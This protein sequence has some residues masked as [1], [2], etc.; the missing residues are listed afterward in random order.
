MYKI[1]P[2]LLTLSAA[3][4]VLSPTARAGWGDW[5][6]LVSDAKEQLG[7]AS[8]SLKDAADSLKSSE[9]VAKAKK[10]WDS[11]EIN[12]R[13]RYAFG[14]DI[15]EKSALTG[16]FFDL[17]R[18]LRKAKDDKGLPVKPAKPGDMPG[19]IREFL[20]KG[21]DSSVLARYY[22]PEV[23]LLAPFFYL[24]RCKAEYA[25]HAFQC[26]SAENAKTV[27]PSC[28]V[29]LYQGVVTAPKSGKFRFVGMCD[30]TMIV[31]FNHKQVLESGWYI[32]TCGDCAT[33]TS[34]AYQQEITT[35]EKDPVALYCYRE[36]PHW[37]KNL[38]GI[39]TGTVFEVEEGE[40]Y[41][42]EI[43]LSE[44]PGSEFGF[45]LL[46][47]EVKGEP[48]TGTYRPWESPVLQLFRTNATFP[49]EERIREAMNDY[50]VGE[51]I[52]CP[53]FA[54]E[55]EV[56]KVDRE[57]TEKAGFWERLLG[58]TPDKDKQT[59][60]GAQDT[61]TADKAE[62]QGNTPKDGGKAGKHK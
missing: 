2:A 55:S 33:G 6:S 8:D 48:K 5:D 56:W 59:A 14:E 10:L 58:E 37:N 60:M 42:I 52:E 4:T 57:E 31:R 41:P 51:Q 11:L 19:I 39:A 7:K 46:V 12:E 40:S 26:D 24:P 9:G 44:I 17:K 32:P 49:E 18:P 1:S 38:G 15:D 23:K 16:H 3:L 62:E 43:L 30:D 36:T 27:R 47:E 45:V 54:T 25:P 34:A 29:V 21:W 35:R 50:L 53:P 22:S 20:D 28:W 13:L 61:A